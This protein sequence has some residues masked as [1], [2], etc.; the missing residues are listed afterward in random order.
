M[1]DIVFYAAANKTIGKVRDFSNM[2]NASA[3]VLTLGVSVCLRMRLFA[4]VNTAT[5]YPIASFS[6]IADWQWSMDSDFDRSTA[7]KLVADAGDISVHTVTDTVDNQTAD[8]TEFVIP[9]SNMNTEELTTWLGT[10]KMKSGLTGELVGYDNEGNSVFVLKIEDFSV[11]NR[12]SGLRAPTAVDEGLVTRTIAEQMIQTAVSASAATKQD[13]LN[14]ANGGTGITVTSTGVIS[15][16]DVPQSAVTGLSASFAAKQDNIV[17]G[18]LIEISGATVNRRRYMTI[19]QLSDMDTISKSPAGSTVNQTYRIMAPGCAYKLTAVGTELY[20]TTETEFAS[21]GSMQWGIESHLEL[22]VA[23]TG[24]LHAD[25]N[26]I[27][28]NAL[29]PD[30]VNNCT[31]RFHNGRAIISVEDHVAGSIVTVNAATNTEGTLKY[32][33]QQAP[34]ADVT[35]NETQ[36]V[37]FDASLNG[38]TLD[39]AGAV[40]NGEKHVVG[41]GYADTILT[42]GVSCTSKTTF[43]NLAMSGVVVTGGTMTLGDVYI[44]QGATVSVSGGGLAVEKVSGNGGV[45]DLGNTTLLV[46]TDGSAYAN[47]CVFTGGANPSV[48]AAIN[49]SATFADCTFSGMNGRIEKGLAGTLVMSGCSIVDNKLLAA[50]VTGPLTATFGG[51]VVLSGCYVSGNTGNYSINAINC[52]SGGTF[53]LSGGNTLEE[54]QNIVFN[55]G[56]GAVTF[57]DSN[58]FLASCY[59]AAGATGSVTISSGAIVDL[60][61]NTNTTPINPGGGVT[62]ELGGATILT[63]ATA[64]VVDKQYALGGMTVPKLGNT[65]TVNLNGSNVVVPSGSTAYASGCNFTSG[66]TSGSTALQQNGGAFRVDE[67]GSLVV[68]GGTFSNCSATRGAAFIVYGTADI[69]NASFIGNYAS[70]FGGAYMVGGGNATVSGCTFSGN[71]CLNNTGN[72]VEIQ[73][74]TTTIKDCQF[75]AGEN[76]RVSAGSA[77]LAGTNKLQKVYGAGGSAIISGGA[78]ITLIDSIA[79]GGGITVLEGGCTVN[80]SAVTAGPYNYI[81][82]ST[83]GGLII[84]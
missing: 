70:N 66:Y 55:N 71:T 76:I 62:F 22:F 64:G 72:I 7:C 29:A 24:R 13:K 60:T 17:A 51:I 49:T 28:A 84:D 35:Y 82:A 32:Y 21:G 59:G 83:T 4:D 18:D 20:L 56:G 38:Q 23:G 30:S 33:L 36:Y 1:Q 8:F 75:E 54:T 12:I 78:I 80:G 46:S 40:T 34:A 2:N 11:S 61:G 50:S 68:S 77:V 79:P 26:V 14:S 42:G 63:G 16:S 31:V 41:N 57:A 10:E 3:P 27:L 69:Y 15:V 25:A 45:I 81:S 19:R 9:I 58:T 39:M 74:G 5:P 65:N 48:S 53:V 6:G 44:P 43:A 73:G 67:G 37:A 52:V 47:G